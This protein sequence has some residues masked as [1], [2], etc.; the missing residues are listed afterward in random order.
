MELGR[1]DLRPTGSALRTTKGKAG[2]HCGLISVTLIHALPGIQRSGAEVT[3]GFCPQDYSCL[4]SIHE[5]EPNTPAATNHTRSQTTVTGWRAFHIPLNQSLPDSKALGQAAGNDLCLEAMV[6][7][8]PERIL[9]PTT[10][11]LGMDS[12]VSAG[13][14]LQQ[15]G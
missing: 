5:N 8:G 11:D 1:S 2:S 15:E 7:E 10:A 9:L 6:N 4:L 13:R 12:W 14:Q 3:Q